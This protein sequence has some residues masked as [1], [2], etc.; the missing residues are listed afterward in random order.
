MPK[1]PASI[2]K[3]LKG[4]P[5]T[6]LQTVCNKLKITDTLEY[7]SFIAKNPKVN[8]PCTTFSVR[9]LFNLLIV[10]GTIIQML[11]LRL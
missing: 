8:N 1:V 3:I 4:V 5:E 11:C 10:L 2:I 6:Q 7:K 9:L